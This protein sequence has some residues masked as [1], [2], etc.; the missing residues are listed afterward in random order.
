MRKYLRRTYISYYSSSWPPTAIHWC[1]IHWWFWPESIFAI[2]VAKYGFANPIISS[3]WNSTFY[4]KKW[5]SLLSFYLASYHCRMTQII[6]FHVWQSIPVPFVLLLKSSQFGCSLLWTRPHQIF[7]ALP[8]IRAQQKYG[9]LLYL[10]FLSPGISHFS[11]IPGT[12]EWEMVL[13]NQ[14]LK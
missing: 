3:R 6:S 2:M 4:C 5:L 11:N 7:W 1:T 13:R 12:S 10:P 8:Y 9:R 14:V